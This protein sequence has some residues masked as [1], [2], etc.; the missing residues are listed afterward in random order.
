[1]RALAE[2]LRSDP[3]VVLLVG[4]GVTNR[5]VAGALIRRGHKVVAL[6]DHPDDSLRNAA[7][8]LGIMLVETPDE[9]ELAR[10]LDRSDV[11]CPTPGLP[12]AHPA[13]HLADKARVPV[14][15]ELD[16]AAL[17]DDRPVLAV[18]GTNGKTTV[19]ELAVA[20]FAEAGVYAVAAGNT[21][22][23]M[24]S[25][26]DDEAAQVFV[27]EASSFRLARSSGF[28]PFVGT[29]LNFAPNHLD[30][31]RD[32]ESY[33]NAKAGL[34]EMT[35]KLGFVV[36]NAQD[37]VVM[38]RQPKGCRAVTFG[39][40]G[41]WHRHG[42]TLVGPD[43][44]FVTIS[45]LW[46]SLPHDIDNALA[47]AASVTPFGVDIAAIVR[48]CESFTLAPHRVQTIATIDGVSYFNDSKATSPHA[49]QAAIR[50]FDKVVLIAGGRNK[51]VDLSPL[52]EERARVQS[53]VA[54]G[55]AAAEIE[56]AF[57]ATC[58][59]VRANSM[60][61]AVAAARVLSL[62]VTPVLFSPGCASFD[63]YANYRERGEDFRR[64]VQALHEKAP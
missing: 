64:V 13:F 43:G 25:A 53:V 56:K 61:E 18:T 1:M 51:G 60:R 21:N 10:L 44:P 28:R 54:I 55:E 48:A 58:D 29:W 6:D 4:M 27:I 35:A 16:L 62:G 7:E 3:G 24:V 47:L 38:S 5:A 34:F 11:L 20:A 33:E 57:S 15:T 42:D 22:V 8:A 26:I 52:A 50:G 32:L 19:V 14:I 39:D 12:E 45:Q 31:H 30:V 36:A 9:A 59:V 37:P 23:P 49:T 63:W 17:W 41:V 46:R 2:T 40:G